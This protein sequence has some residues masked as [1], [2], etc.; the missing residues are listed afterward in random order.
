MPTYEPSCIGNLTETEIMMLECDISAKYFNDTGYA[1]TK[2]RFSSGYVVPLVAPG[3][4]HQFTDDVIIHNKA[5]T[6]ICKLVDLLKIIKNSPNRIS[7][8]D[9]IM[10]EYSIDQIKVHDK[11]L[12]LLAVDKLNELHD[13]YA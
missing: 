4:S 5:Y 2:H 12:N 3:H 10:I 6:V 13:K 11:S 9:Y 1:T 8:E 7:A